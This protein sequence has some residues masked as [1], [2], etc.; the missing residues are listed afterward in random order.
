M[1]NSAAVLDAW[2]CVK[3]L[4]PEAGQ[5]V[6]AA[7]VLGDVFEAQFHPQLFDEQWLQAWGFRRWNGKHGG[8]LV[9]YVVTHWKPLPEHPECKVVRVK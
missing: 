1:T 5:R 7:D 9:S 4:R 8:A 3:E 2:I 6:L